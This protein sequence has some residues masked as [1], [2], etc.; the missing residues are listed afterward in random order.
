MASIDDTGSLTVNTLT[1]FV[2]KQVSTAFLVA[3]M[4]SRFTSWYAYDFIFN[5]AVRSMDLYPAYVGRIP[6]RRINFNTPEEERKQL[7]EQARKLYQEYL[8]NQN[9]D[10]VIA[11]VAERLPQKLDGTPDMEHEQ[12]DVVHDLLAFLAEE[13]TRL[14]KEKQSRIE[15]F[16][17]WLE[18]EILKGSVEDQKNKTK[19]KGF[20]E[21]SF[22]DLLD[23]LKKNKVVKD[24]CPADT[25]DTIAGE[26]S[27]AMTGLTPLKD[28]I[29]ATDKLIDQV[30]YKLYGL[31]DDE[32]AI[33]EGRE[34][35]KPA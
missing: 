8:D 32:I 33:V 34:Y 3:I 21:S 25:R 1:D 14:N 13:M 7:L 29:A 26:F 22:E 5:R 15:S 20:H 30:V 6:I 11:F 35:S 16:L 27:A 24:P 18:K 23:V 19:I 28:H 12:S 4:N 31:T 10:K 17:T 9:W 2:G